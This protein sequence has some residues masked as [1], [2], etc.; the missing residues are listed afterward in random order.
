MTRAKTQGP[1]GKVP[2]AATQSGG[3]PKRATTHSNLFNDLEAAIDSLDQ[4][5]ARHSAPKP[6]DKPADKPAAKLPLPKRAAPDPGLARPP[7]PRPVYRTD[8]GPTPG[9]EAPKFPPRTVPPKP[10]PGAERAAIIRAREARAASELGQGDA[11]EVATLPS[12][13]VPPRPP[14]GTRPPISTRPL[15]ADGLPPISHPPPRT[16]PRPTPSSPRAESEVEERRVSDVEDP[17]VRARREPSRSPNAEL[18]SISFRPAPEPRRELSRLP[19]E[20]LD[21]DAVL[22]RPLTLELDDS[23]MRAER[24]TGLSIDVDLEESQSAARPYEPP[25]PQPAE[26]VDGD[27]LPS[28][29]PLSIAILDEP[30]Y[31][32]AAKQAI[33]VAGHK[34]AAAASG[35]TGIEQIKSLLRTGIADVLLVGMPGGEELIDT[36]LALAPRRPVVIAVFSGKPA[37]A[38]RRAIVLGAD[39]AVARPLDLDKL[40]PVLLAAS[41][42][43]VART[44][45]SAAR[46]SDANLRGRLD[47]M[48][49]HEP[50]ALQP[51]A[52][53]ERVFEL[54]IKRSK[55][56]GYP[57]AIAL[58]SI[59]V[60]GEPPPGM[61]GIVRARAGNALIQSIRDIDL[62]TEVDDRFLVLLPYTTLRGAAE[63]ARRILSAVTGGVPISAAGK[64]YPP[65]ITGSVAGAHAGESLSIARLMRDA[66]QALE[67]AERDGAELAVPM[68]SRD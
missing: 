46:T 47:A 64:T 15:D 19:S 23:G 57:I 4:S 3:K 12:P 5:S 22:Q 52:A 54:E 2:R 25:A 58:F 39:L 48:A 43:A 65:T 10:P 21:D 18:L 20:Q 66:T 29:E 38:V 1:G 16:T 68:G 67:E 61:L 31:I 17:M 53:F 11:E 27:A 36:A 37:E 7:T 40:A 24:E 42:L 45:A 9:S 50:G 49:D 44:T 59:E 55:R 63:V 13:R 62:A 51:F 56:Y 6:E 35:Q 34:V 32:A 33:A 28:I 14:P 30:P 26:V 41:R 60:D 8:P